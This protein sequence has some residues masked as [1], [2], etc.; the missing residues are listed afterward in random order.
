MTSVPLFGSMAVTRK[1]LPTGRNSN[2]TSESP[3]GNEVFLP[4]LN[5]R[6][7]IIKALFLTYSVS[8]PQ[9]DMYM[10]VI[11]SIYLAFIWQY[12]FS[13]DVRDYIL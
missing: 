1:I 10:R 5:D 3:S 7:A 8:T 2:K 4:L 6:L 12:L 9:G 13:F 11:V